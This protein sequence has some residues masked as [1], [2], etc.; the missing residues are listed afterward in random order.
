MTPA[1]ARRDREPA[2]LSRALFAAAGFVPVGC[3]CLALFG[4]LPLVLSARRVVLPLSGLAILAGARHRS[5]GR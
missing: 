2:R 5:L 4:L 1:S 3:L